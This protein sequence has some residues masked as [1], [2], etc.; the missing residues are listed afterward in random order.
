MPDKRV[1]RM[2]HTKCPHCGAVWGIAL[3]PISFRTP[4]VSHYRGTCVCGHPLK[5][6]DALGHVASLFRLLKDTP[7]AE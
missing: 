7:N 5:D 6:L 1:P 4:N 3:A 2:N